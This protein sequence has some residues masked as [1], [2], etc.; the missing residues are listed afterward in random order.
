MAS[1]ARLGSLLRLL[2][3]REVQRHQSDDE[4]FKP[5]NVDIDRVLDYIDQALSYIKK[6]MPNHD[7]TVHITLYLESTKRELIDERPSWK[8]VVGT[9]VIVATIL[10]GVAA[11]PEAYRNVKAAL[12]H[13]LGTS[14]ERLLLPPAP[15]SL[16]AD[17]YR[18]LDD[19][20][21]ET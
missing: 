2:F 10:G 1:A 7:Y 9:L 3:E 16:P 5:S 4:I 15:P 11:A 21:I 13:I 20:I 19:E 14:V 17:P 6:E 8:N 12:D 18:H